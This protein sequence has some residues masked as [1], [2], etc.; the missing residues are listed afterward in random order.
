M[1][2]TAEQIACIM[3]EREWE[4]MSPTV[5]IEHLENRRIAR[6]NAYLKFYEIEPRVRNIL[7]TSFAMSRGL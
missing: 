1:K 6:H 3:F 7:V 5:R 4:G 2:M